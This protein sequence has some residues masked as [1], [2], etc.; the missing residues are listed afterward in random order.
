MRF[1]VL[2]LLLMLPVSSSLRKM[3]HLK[4]VISYSDPLRPI[5]EA[6]YAAM[7]S[8]MAARD[9]SAISA[10]ITPDFDSEDS[11]GQKI[12]GDTMVKE[13]VALPK[14][15]QKESTTTILAIKVDGNTATIDQRYDMKTVKSGLFGG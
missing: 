1:L 11:S 9:A 4:K 2:L 8:A 5:F 6:R 7:K 13:V 15:P 14:D 12:N 3:F 10:L